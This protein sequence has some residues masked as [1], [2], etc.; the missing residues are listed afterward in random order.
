MPTYKNG[1]LYEIPITDL[2][3]DP[4]QPRKSIDA[5]ALSEMTESVKHVGIIQPILFRVEEGNPYLIV[6]AGERRLQASRMAGLTTIRGICV[7]GN[8]TEIALIENMQRQDLTCVEEA[9]AFKRLM[10]EQKY[11]Q[12][13][14]AAV[15]G[16]ART[17]VS[18]LLQINRLPQ[19][20]RD[21]CRGNHDITK[22]TLIEIA[23]KKQARSMVKAYEEYKAKQIK[24]QQGKIPRK[25]TASGDAQ[26]LFDFLDKAQTKIY[27][28]DTS[29]WTEDERATFPISLNALKASIETA[30]ANAS[31]PPSARLA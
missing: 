5:E 27:I 16:K 6:V 15:I 23:R 10:D 11:T 29:A 22:S 20:I 21:E 1:K 14:L 26:A 18:D 24:K 30:L 8:T 4:N 2:I 19:Q 3:P 31:A 7:E 17:T 13:K 12:E 9:E 28:V 25:K